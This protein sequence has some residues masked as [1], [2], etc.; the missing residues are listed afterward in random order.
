MSDIEKN[1]SQK[2][3]Y[4]KFS[5]LGL[6]CM[7]LFLLWKI[8]ELNNHLAV[9]EVTSK[10][11]ES[12]Q[13]VIETENKNDILSKSEIIEHVRNKTVGM[14]I[15]PSNLVFHERL[16]LY[17]AQYEGVMFYI[18]ADG[19]YLVKGNV[20]DLEVL[21]H[22]P[23]SADLTKS[24]QAAL[25]LVR[26]DYSANEYEF[27]GS[28]NKNKENITKLLSELPKE[29]LIAFE[30]SS[31]KD[32]WFVFF[33]FT[34]PKCNDFF[35]EIKKAV[36]MGIKVYLAPISRNPNN[37][38]SQSIAKQVLCQT[39]PGRSASLFVKSGMGLLREC[40]TDNSAVQ[41]AFSK[42]AP[43]GT[44]ATYSMFTGNEV[45][46]AYKVSDIAKKLNL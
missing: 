22:S 45:V 44:P 37:L 35:P 6:G 30:P 31:Q 11:F 40:E 16:K 42:L 27:P 12:K 20:I 28:F 8:N 43:R 36:A 7:S 38:Y 13:V 18:S 14:E 24:Y 3:T 5:M 10:N 2:S 9:K 25:T 29:Q 17:Q 41:T 39:N 23:D 1:D 21:K 34:C 26:G 15:K 46:G 19:T 4:F 33:D 32:T